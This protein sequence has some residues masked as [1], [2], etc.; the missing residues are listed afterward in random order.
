ME[1]MPIQKVQAITGL[2]AHTL[3][4]YEKAG[5]MIAPV[6][7]AANGHR[8]YTEEDV[9]WLRFLHRLRET[10]MPIADIRRY[11]E[12]ARQGES[13]VRDRL[14]LLETH[15]DAVRA[16]L[17]QT[18]EYLDSIERK[19]DHYHDYYGDQLAKARVA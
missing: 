12:L 18:T 2:S 14:S 17:Q 19:I 5:L 16:H 15:R 13:T 7:R 4:Y 3:R 11:A 6:P 10:G 1:G 9:Y 8:R